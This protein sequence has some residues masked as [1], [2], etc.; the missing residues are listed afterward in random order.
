MFAAWTTVGRRTGSEK[1]GWSTW[2]RGRRTDSMMLMHTGSGGTTLVSLPRDS[3]VPIA[4]H[5]S[6]KLNAAFAFGGPQLLVR[7]VEQATG[8]HI[9]HYAEVG[10]GGFVGVVDA[11]GGVRMC[12]KAP[13]K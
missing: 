6:N 3:Y 5:G 7:T 13:M 4:G 2:Q 12:I 1:D 11:V 10:F 8:V 9:D